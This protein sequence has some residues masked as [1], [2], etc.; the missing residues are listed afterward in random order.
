MK[1][2]NIKSYNTI[3]CIHTISYYIQ[4]V[5]YYNILLCRVILN[6]I[7]IGGTKKKH[8]TLFSGK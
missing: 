3:Y 8:T 5:N 7:I 2:N 6:N 1:T 4:I